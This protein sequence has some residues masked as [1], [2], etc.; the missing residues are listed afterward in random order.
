MSQEAMCLWLSQNLSL[1]P[2]FFLVLLE[3]SVWLSLKPSPSITLSC[4][5]S[6]SLF[7]LSISQS[8][9]LTLSLTL[10]PTFCLFFRVPFFCLEVSS[11]SLLFSSFPFYSFE[12]IYIFGLS[13]A[14]PFGL[15]GSRPLPAKKLLLL[16]LLKLHVSIAIDPLLVRRRLQ[17]MRII[18]IIIFIIITPPAFLGLRCDNVLEF[19]LD[20]LLYLFLPAPQWLSCLFEI[21]C[22]SS[23]VGLLFLVSIF[24]FFCFF[25]L[26]LSYTGGGVGCGSLPLTVFF[27]WWYFFFFCAFIPSVSLW[28]LLEMELLHL[29]RCF[30]T[31]CLLVCLIFCPFFL[32]LF[33]S[34]VGCLEFGL[35]FFVFLRVT[36]ISYVHEVQCGSVRNWAGH[37]RHLFCPV[38]QQCT[39]KNPRQT[40]QQIIREVCLA[41]RSHPARRRLANIATPV[42]KHRSS[43]GKQKEQKKEKKANRQEETEVWQSAAPRGC[44]CALPF[45]IFFCLFF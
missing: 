11:Q 42:E 32:F 16:L 38:A 4:N 5:L 18:I 15:L 10:S 44:S 33:S 19:I 13:L 21:I 20:L 12:S 17:V 28:P 31:P 23:V 26:L 36:V 30:V 14:L 24:C 45:C 8:V 27:F 6:P 41:H 25:G 40:S 2:I 22:H 35:L 1:S 7:L 29:D 3:I 34:L 39:Q 37:Q 9:S 43:S